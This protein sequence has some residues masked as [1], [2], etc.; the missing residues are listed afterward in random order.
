MRAAD[1]AVLSES[2]SRSSIPT[3]CAA[4]STGRVDSLTGDRADAEAARIGRR[5]WLRAV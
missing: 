5:K 4:G 3:S 1:E 2:P